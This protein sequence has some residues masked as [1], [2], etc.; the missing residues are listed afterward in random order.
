MA[1]K[2]VGHDTNLVHKTFGPKDFCSKKNLL[3]KI[4]AHKILGSQS[5]VK[6]GSLTAEI[7]L[8]CTNVPNDVCCLDKCH[9]EDWPLLKSVKETY[10]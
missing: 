5:L 9:H 2:K 10:V 7:L 3:I 6:M 1:L 8:I 4:K